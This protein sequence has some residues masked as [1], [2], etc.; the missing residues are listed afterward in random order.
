MPFMIKVTAKFE[1]LLDINIWLE[2][3]AK[4]L[5]LSESNSFAIQLCCE[6]AFMNIVMHSYGPHCTEIKDEDQIVLLTIDQEG[7]DITLTIRDNGLT[8]NPLEASEPTHPNTLS[9]AKIG[10]L[11]ISLMK[12]FSKNIQYVSKD[13][14]NLLTFQF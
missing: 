8:F 5:N 7:R 2:A 10:G 12:K 14:G 11:G 3:V 6:E 13:M 9:E 1:K 4:N